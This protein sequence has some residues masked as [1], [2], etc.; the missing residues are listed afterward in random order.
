MK[1][2]RDT[3]RTVAPEDIRPGD[4][5][6]IFTITVEWPPFYFGDFNREIVRT[7][8][9]PCDA[10][11]PL[12]V[13]AVCLPFI[14]VIDHKDEPATIDLRRSRVVRLTPRYAEKVIKRFKKAAKTPPTAVS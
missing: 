8:H 3:S 7:V 9:M 2:I 1:Q 13:D 5:V 4:F 12:R 11:K 6:A 10:G 14:L